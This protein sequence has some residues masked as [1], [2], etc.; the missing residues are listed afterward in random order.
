MQ[1]TITARH[2]DIP[3]DL[4]ARAEDLVA[5]LAKLATR[6]TSAHVTF[7]QEKARA[8]AEVVLNAARG[9]VHVA[10]AAADDHRT[11]LDRVAAKLRRQLDKQ[12]PPARRARKAGVR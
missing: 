6:P 5:R 9:A 7:D 4:R 12:E 10:A 1:V 3:E 11:A 2:S 8:T